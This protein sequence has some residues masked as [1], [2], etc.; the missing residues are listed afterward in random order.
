MTR[1][2]SF[3]T[4]AA[5]RTE[6]PLVVEIDG[7]PI[8]MRTWVDIVDLGLLVDRVNTT[9]ETTGEGRFGTLGRKRDA[10]MDAIRS[11]VDETALPDWDRVRPTVDVSTGTEIVR[12]LVAEYAGT[13][14]PTPPPSSP[15]GS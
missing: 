13:A 15:D 1:H 10:I 14:D 11:C 5:R 7:T 3:T 4:A 12:L 8:R 2:H 6:D 9:D